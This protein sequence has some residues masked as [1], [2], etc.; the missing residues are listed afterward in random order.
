MTGSRGSRDLLVVCCALAV[1]LA[2]LAAVQYRWSARVAAADAQREREHL[3][4]SAAL[5]ANEFNDLG[6]KA[7]EFLQSEAWNA[8]KSGQPLGNVPKLIADLYYLEVPVAGEPKTQRLSADGHFASISIPDWIAPLRC[9]PRTSTTPL[10]IVSPVFDLE[11]M[12]KATGSS[13]SIVGTFGAKLSRCFIARLN[14]S[15]LRDEAFPQMIRRSFGESS[16][17][18]YSF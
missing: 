17:A 10:V 6:S 8:V 7:V 18:D 12:H 2:V 1:L 16:V 14:E 5:F 11:S 9:T 15:Y 4:A 3:D 13:V